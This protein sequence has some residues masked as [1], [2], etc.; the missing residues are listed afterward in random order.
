VSR[1]IAC[2]AAAAFVAA[3][4][5]TREATPRA[6]RA[7][8]PPP[9][10]SP[11]A[12]AAGRLLYARHCLSCHQADGGGV[13]N[14]QPA[15]AGG[16]WV[17]GDA[18]ALAAFVMTGGFDSASRKDAGEGNVMPPFAQ[19]SDADLAE[20]LTF[21]RTEFGKGAP[22]VTAAEVAQARASLPK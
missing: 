9:A 5:T 20:L 7:E 4:C 19:L 22:P 10:S 1:A 16:A 3:A 15:I 14:M 12:Q 17:S 13:P 21:I 11:G 2:L 8:G 18:R 6:P